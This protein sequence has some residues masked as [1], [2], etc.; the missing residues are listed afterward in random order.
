LKHKNKKDVTKDAS[1]RC[2]LPQVINWLNQ[3]H[4]SRNKIGSQTH[5][6]QSRKL[7]A[8]PLIVIFSQSSFLWLVIF[9][10]KLIYL[11]IFCVRQEKDF[12]VRSRFTRC[13]W[14][15]KQLIFFFYLNSMVL[16]IIY[17]VHMYSGLW[18]FSSNSSVEN[19]FSK[20][21]NNYKNNF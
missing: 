17:I 1:W 14:L 21:E 13:W 12:L 19:F 5:D 16:M 2:V 8:L 20:L 15:S 9:P 4:Y 18:V 10:F 3:K 11:I 7:P 6:L